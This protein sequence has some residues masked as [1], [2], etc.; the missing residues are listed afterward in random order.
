MC[1]SKSKTISSEDAWW[2]VKLYY[3]QNPVPETHP[4]RN[5]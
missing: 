4:P 5:T 1:F 2:V 3:I